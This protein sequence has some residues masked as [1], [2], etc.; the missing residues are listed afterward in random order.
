MTI[1]EI[2]QLS[3]CSISSVSR[4]LNNT[5]GVRPEVRERVQ[6]IIMEHNYTPNRVARDLAFQKTRL[7]ALIIPGVNSYFTPMTEGIRSSLSQEGYEMFILSGDRTRGQTRREI[8]ALHLAYEKQVEGILFLPLRIEEEHIQF[9]ESKKHKIPLLLI[10][11]DPHKLPYP[12]VISEGYSSIKSLME[13][14]YSKGVRRFA[15]LRGL[16]YLQEVHN[17]YQAFVDF[18]QEKGLS[19]DPE[20]VVRG[21]MDFASGRE[22]LPELLKRPQKPEALICANDAMAIGALRGAYEMG[23]SVPEDLMITGFDGLET[24][25]YTTPSLTTV[26]QNMEELGREGAQLLLRSLREGT[27]PKEKVIVPSSLMIR[28]SAPLDQ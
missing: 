11:K 28:E 23:I 26:I 22:L 21:G 12:R 16:E 10:N 3:Q 19:L 6:K 1:Y 27:S 7:I 18:H 8:E 9:F 15:M 2:A 14:M 4:V 25:A 20:Q 5:P 17:R 24:G 13:K